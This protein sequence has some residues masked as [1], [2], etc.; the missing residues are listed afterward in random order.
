MHGLCTCHYVCIFTTCLAMTELVVALILV[1]ARP[2]RWEGG[3]G[4]MHM[5]PHLIE[6]LAMGLLSSPQ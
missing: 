3:R 2:V 1:L 5:H 4:G 6:G